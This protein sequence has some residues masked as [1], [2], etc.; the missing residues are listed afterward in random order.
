M[1]YPRS[2]DKELSQ[3]LFANPSA[4]Y[5]GVPFWS[6]NT[7]I[8][9]ELVLEQIAQFSEMGF[10]G[11]MIHSR[12]GLETPYMG[13]E[14][15]RFVKLALDEC[16][17][18]GMLTWLYDEDRYPSGSA[19]GM[20]T[21]DIAYRAR[22]LLLTNKI[23]PELCESK[24]DYDTAYASNKK[25]KG[26]YLASYKIVLENGYLVDY[27]V[28]GRHTPGENIWHAYLRLSEESPWYNGQTYLDTLNKKAVERFIQLTHNK[29]YEA[30]GASFGSSI[31]AIFTDEPQL[32]P[33]RTLTFATESN[34]ASVPWTDDLPQSYFTTYK[35]SLM[36]FVPELFWQ[37]PDGKISRAR[38]RYHD[39]VTERFASAFMD[40]IGRWCEKHGILFTGHLMSERLLLG[41]TLAIGE[42]MRHYRAFQLPGVDVLVGQLELSTLKQAT[43]V[44]AQDGREGVISELYGV[45]EWDADFKTYKLQGDWQMALGVTVRNLHLQFMSMEGESKRD[46][47]AS[48]G[49]QSPWWHKMSYVEDY[50]ARVATVLTRGKSYCRLAVLHPIESYWVN[51]GPNNQTAAERDGREEN[52]ENL[53]QWLLFGLMDFHFIA[54]SLLPAQCKQGGAPLRVGEMQYDTILVPDCMTLRGTTVDRLEAFQDAGGRL[55]FAG[56][57][58]THVDAMPS[59]RL[60]KLVKKAEIVSY[61]R[62]D[63][64]AAL[65][66]CRAIEVKTKLGKPSDNLFYNMREDGAGRWLFICHVK[67]RNNRTGRPEQYK[68]RIRGEWRLTVYN[69]MTGRTNEVICHYRN[70][71]YTCFDFSFYAEDSL[72]LHLEA[73]S[74]SPD[75]C[76]SGPHLRNV[77]ECKCVNLAE[78]DPHLAQKP[79]VIYKPESY[80]L[81]ES[82]ALLLD[83]PSW[84]VDGGC[85]HDPDEILRVDNAVRAKLGFPRR[86]DKIV[87]PWMLA[88]E[89]ARH[90]VWLSY[91]FESEMVL[92]GCK[93]A[94]ERSKEATIY[95]NGIEITQKANGWYVDKAI[96]TVPLPSLNKGKN[97]LLVQIPFSPRANLEALYILGDFGV[98][99]D[100]RTLTARPKSLEFGD[101]TRQGLPFYTGNIHYYMRFDIEK[102]GAVTVQVPHYA[103][104]ALVFLVDGEEKGVAAYSPHALRIE[105]LSRGSHL[106]EIVLLGNRFNGFGNLHNAN[107]EYMWYGPDSYR[108]EGDEWCDK[109][110]LRPVGILSR[111]ELYSTKIDEPV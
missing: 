95:L 99:G 43:S 107:S 20:V 25:P 78:T 102:P 19:G 84:R 4:E 68:A 54:E 18:R 8:T 74:T 109:Y 44:A 55:L 52:F 79:I 62:R 83:R 108:T 45:T 59:D 29:Y 3:S 67:R 89:P 64:L 49:Y 75:T 32:Q 23:E 24:T 46:W 33:K 77:Y 1:L 30:V 73:A 27:E 69:A 47:P 7:K 100:L 22:H 39:H 110:L 103:G 12:T 80:K 2:K 28:V 50:F 31:P 13:D 42:A 9:D 101:I 87:Q 93:L 48:I 63:V 97:E 98:G 41:Q 36:D 26:Y 34:N 70:D 51:Y 17:K 60:A 58:P 14:F 88:H 92:E 66:P 16:K 85:W 86:Q 106:L 37:L 15:M 81:T 90:V 35:E 57:I 40:T 21:E 104:T 82:A 94:I 6:W 76:R 105:G 72:L 38:Y 71:G 111:V 53:L 96:H 65:E 91:T 61:T 10:G 5:R 56:K 11:A